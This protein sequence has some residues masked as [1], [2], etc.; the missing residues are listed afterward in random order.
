[1]G[2]DRIAAVERVDC[3]GRK[4]LAG[5]VGLELLIELE[6]GGR[7]SCREG[8]IDEFAGG[9]PVGNLT[10]FVMAKHVA[11]R[12]QGHRKDHLRLNSEWK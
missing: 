2:A 10:H 11:Y 12:Q 7:V 6:S 4:L 9:Q 3:R 1:V 5:V 8:T